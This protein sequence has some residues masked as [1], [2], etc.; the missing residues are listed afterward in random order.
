MKSFCRFGEW[1]SEAVAR[2][3]MTEPGKGLFIL[4]WGSDRHVQM[5]CKNTTATT[6]LLSVAWLSPSLVRDGALLVSAKSDAAASRSVEQLWRASTQCAGC[7]IA[8]V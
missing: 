6:P 4:S 7:W 5:Q 3:Y 8:E 2:Q 1:E